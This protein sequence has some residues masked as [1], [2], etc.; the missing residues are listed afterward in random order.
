MENNYNLSGLNYR[1]LFWAVLAFVV[2]ISLYFLVSINQKLNTA[3]TTNTVSFSGE[4]K[5]ITKPDIAVID[6]SIVTEGTTSKAAQDENSRKSKTLTDFLKKQNIEEKDIKTTSYNIYPQ[7]N[8][9]PYEAPRITGYQVNQ[10]LQVKVRDLDITD[11]IL[12]GIVSA[13][14]NQINGFNL[15]I[16]EPEELQAQAREEAIQDAKAK[17]A[18]LQKQL[19]VRLGKI[20]NFVEN[21]SGYP[22]PMY[23]DGRG[24][25]GGGGGVSPSIPTGENEISVQV[26]ITY[27]IR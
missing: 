2:I 22:T 16:D 11:K 7:Y 27:Q 20:V 18:V 23:V 6:V 10:A 3:A 8:Y 25:V 15:S 4:G 17:A 1:W 21:T 13:G 12:D 9:K 24:G 19:G 14:V 5:V 26:T